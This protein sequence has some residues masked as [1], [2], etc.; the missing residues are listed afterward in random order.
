MEIVVRDG[1]QGAWPSSASA[2]RGEVGVGRI[3]DLLEGQAVG[4][5][6]E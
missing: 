5:H 3:G 2:R 1:G 4:R 6:D